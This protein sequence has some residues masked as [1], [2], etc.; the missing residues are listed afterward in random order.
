MSAYSASA[1]GSVRHAARALNGTA[2]QAPPVLDEA[3]RDPE[4]LARVRLLAS[5][6]GRKGWPRELLWRAHLEF[7]LS[8][9][10]VRSFERRLRR[11]R[12]LRASLG[13]GDAA[14]SRDTLR[15]FGKRAAAD[16]VLRRWSEAVRACRPRADGADDDA[17]LD[18]VWAALDLRELLEELERAGKPGRTGWPAEP[19]LRALV[20]MAHLG[21]PTL[22]ELLRTLR[23][24]PA[25]ALWCG[26]APGGRRARP[27]RWALARFADRISRRLDLTTAASV[28][29]GA[30][31]VRWLPEFGKHVAVDRTF[32]RAW[33]NSRKTERSDGDARF[34]FS[35]KNR[36]RGNAEL[37]IGYG[38]H[39]AACAETDIPLSALLTPANERETKLFRILV[40]STFSLLRVERPEVV[41][42]DKGYDS[43]DNAAFVASFGAS[44]V[45]AIRRRRRGPDGGEVVDGPGGVRM[46]YDGTPLCRCGVPMAFAGHTGAFAGRTG[47]GDIRLRRQ[48]WRC[49]AECGAG[50]ITIEWALDPRRT[51]Y[52]PRC[53][54]E[55]RAAERRH[56]A[57]ERCHHLL[58]DVGGFLSEHRVRGMWKVGFRL[59]FG[60]LLMQARA[61]AAC[62]DGRPQ[63]IRKAAIPDT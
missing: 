37:D 38:V 4:A 61:L 56:Q 20:A 11:S 59:H 54:A 19:K 23:R 2:P 34:G 52:Q 53:S 42:A 21:I 43:R 44:P 35:T 24:S 15:R 40:A 12:A 31:L 36:G 63:D 46:R 47:G 29:L 25:L 16:P 14:P 48:I 58:K 30:E 5:P 41:T 39:L 51:P 32:V 9:A 3:A 45:I 22:A 50:P 26:F 55:Y 1:D 60:I 6:G 28:R 27:S 17:A 10:G 7:L 18:R 8:G 33:S 49:S 57:V 13:C 62:R